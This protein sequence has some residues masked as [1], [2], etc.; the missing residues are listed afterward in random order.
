MKRV[1]TTVIIALLPCLLFGMWNIGNMHY[2]NMAAAEKLAEFGVG[3]TPG[4]MDYF[5]YG[6][7]QLVPII[8][9]CYIVGLG[10]EFTFATLR[11]HS[12]SEGFLVSGILIPLVVPYTIPLWEV[13][14]AT[15]FAVILGKEVF[16]GTGYNLLNPALTARAFLFFAYPAQISGNKVWIDTADGISGATVLGQAADPVLDVT[17]NFSDMLFGF[18][19]GSIGETSAIACALGAFILI[20]TGVG[21]WRIMLSMLIGGLA[22]SYLVEIATFMNASDELLK[23]LAD[24]GDVTGY[25]GVDHFF[26]HIVAGGFMFGL[27]FMA[28]DPVSAAHTNMGKL[29]Y[30]LFAGAMA[31]LVRF[32]NP[33]YPEGVMLAI[34]LA[35]VFAPLF[36]YFVI[37]SNKKRRLN[38]ATV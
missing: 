33:A 26:Y 10:I 16:G 25:F 4:F 32:W 23:Q 14:L 9:V 34:L 20:A 22:M 7:I 3:V 6:A 15:A 8:A 11:R 31:I 24:S 13:A 38:R 29:Y 17:Y 36:D 2:G 18:I 19:P 37:S 5:I 27:V 30:G 21:S 12:V 1:M 35:N 28:T